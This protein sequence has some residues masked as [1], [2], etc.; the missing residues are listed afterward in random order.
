MADEAAGRVRAEVR[1]PYAIA[2]A[3]TRRL[4]EALSTAT[5]KD[6]TV[7]SE[8]DASVIGGVVARVGDLTFDGSLKTQLK[9][10]RAQVLEKA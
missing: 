8:V 3:D 5:G 9:T 6:V 2:D 1:A 4:A 7:T 10:L